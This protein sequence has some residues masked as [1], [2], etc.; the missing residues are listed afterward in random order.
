MDSIDH[1]MLIAV[2]IVSIWLHCLEGQDCDFWCMCIEH[3]LSGVGQN[4]DY[5]SMCYI[6]QVTLTG[7]HYTVYV[8]SLLLQ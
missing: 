4:Y 5:W 7:G 3:Y 2:Y 6:L 8:I 1:I